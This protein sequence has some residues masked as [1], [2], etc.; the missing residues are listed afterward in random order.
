MVVAG[1]GGK[2]IKKN[3]VTTE[4][5]RMLQCCRHL[6]FQESQ[7]PQDITDLCE[8]L[9]NSFTMVSQMLLCGECYEN[10]HA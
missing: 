10:V 1:S 8:C 7:L 5:R 2:N 4:H 6:G 3:Y 9:K